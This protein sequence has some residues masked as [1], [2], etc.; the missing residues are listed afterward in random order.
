MTPSERLATLVAMEKQLK[1]ILDD[2]KSE[3]RQYL[4]DVHD[5]CGADRIPI[6]V[7]KQKVGEIGL[8]Y[9]K[10]KVTIDPNNRKA[11]MNILEE[12]GLTEQIPVK[13]WESHFEMIGGQIMSKDTGEVV[14][15]FLIEEPTVKAAAIRGCKPDDVAKAFNALGN[16]PTVF[17]F[18]ADMEG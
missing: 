16:A 11:A 4:M 5:Q 18:L 1:P 9:S 8:S 7:G 12:L 10:E 17:G 6:S 2:A 13:G 15:G 3:A 14:D